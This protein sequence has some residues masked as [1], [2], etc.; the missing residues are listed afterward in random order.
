MIVFGVITFVL[1][2]LIS[3]L[4]LKKPKIQ[5]CGKLSQVIKKRRAD[6]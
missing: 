1:I 5:W 6:V 3:N 2:I 4:P